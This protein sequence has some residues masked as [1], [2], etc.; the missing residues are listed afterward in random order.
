[1]SNAFRM[2]EYASAILIVSLSS[3]LYLGRRLR[4]RLYVETTGASDVPYLGQE[5]PEHEK[6]HGTAIICGGSIAGLL[7][8]RICHNHF[9]RVVIIEP[10]PWLASEQAQMV[11]GWKQQHKRS[12]IVQY[13]SVQAQ[14]ALNLKAYR[15]MFPHF[16]E[17]AKASGIR[18]AASDLKM[19]ISG[20][21]PGVP[22]DEYPDGLPETCFTSRQGL[23]TLIRRLVKDTTKYPNIDYIVGSVS[24]YHPAAG[25]STVLGGITVRNEHGE[26]DIRADLVIDCTGVFRAGVKM[27]KHA[28]YG[29]ADVYPKGKLSLDDIKLSYDP[30]MFYST[31]E[32]TIPPDLAKR[33]PIP[34]GMDDHPAIAMCLSNARKDRKTL[35]L[36]GIDGPYRIHISS[37]AWDIADLPK[38]IDG[39]K[40]FASSMIMDVPLPSWLFQLLDMLGEDPQV[41]ETMT[42]SYIRVPPS[43]YYRFHQAAKLPSNWVALGDSVMNIN[44]I[45]GTGLAK[46]IYGLICLS[47]ILRTVPPGSSSTLNAQSTTLPADFS[48]NFFNIQKAKIENFWTS[49]KN[50]DYAQPTTVPVRGESLKKGAW[51][52]WYMRRLRIVSLTDKATSSKFW[53]IL[54]YLSPGIDAL[55]PRF[56]FKVLWS[57]VKTPE[58]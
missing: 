15:A 2:L 41:H 12:R 21:F 11:E 24:E 53:H 40:K 49:T 39:V 35:Y 33:L 16:D 22:Y 14:Q 18:I 1:M 4:Q 46:A 38:T 8:A 30:K 32:L 3:C 10:E 5:R 27:L 57:Y 20:R 50:A 36:I 23:E 44:P 52:R 55:H 42:V 25:N 9:K 26:T 47:Q 43:C 51:M 13:H 54:N 48:T 17:Q 34:G 6:L 28:G 29:F 31:L 58:I 45:F 19:C 37:G 7:S 56:V